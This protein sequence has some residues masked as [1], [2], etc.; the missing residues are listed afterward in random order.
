VPV[1]HGDFRSE[2][3]RGGITGGWGEGFDKLTD[4]LRS[5]APKRR[6]TA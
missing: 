1:V 4:L 3:L 6:R 2:P 5:T